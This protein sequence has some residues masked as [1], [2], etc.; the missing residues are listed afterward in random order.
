MS[1][2]L[3][4]SGTPQRPGPAKPGLRRKSPDQ[5]IAES[6]GDLEGHGLKRTMGLFQLVCFGIGAIVGTG[7]F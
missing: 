4:N 5:L 1:P 2:G 3:P 6:G 7:I